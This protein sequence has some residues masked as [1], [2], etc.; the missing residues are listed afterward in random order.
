MRTVFV[1]LA[2]AAVLL[3]TASAV[4]AATIQDLQAMGFTVN[5]V[6]T[7]QNNQ[8]QTCT[9]YQITGFGINEQAG[10]C[11]PDFQA[12]IDSLANPTAQC[13]RVWQINHPDQTQAF[14]TLVNKGYAISGDQCADLYTVADPAT[15]QTVYS[16]PGAGLV[17]EAATLETA[18]AGVPPGNPQAP[19][20]ST[21]PT[22]LPLCPTVTTTTTTT[23][24]VAQ[25]D[26]APPAAS[27][28]DV[29]AAAVAHAD[30]FVGLS[31]GEKA[32]A[33]ITTGG[34]LG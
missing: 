27:T 23:T 6:Y 8:G 12:Q 25:V 3:L 11:D 7:V 19:A 20:A 31:V 32:R 34:A 24:T 15:G 16:G 1:S 30:A 14:L 29:R 28:G 9:A 5:V 17:N 18:G 21:P 33:G 2:A 13:N 22:C 4:G 26:T 10:S